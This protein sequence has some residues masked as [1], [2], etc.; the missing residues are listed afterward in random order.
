MIFD[1]EFPKI[2]VHILGVMW[3]SEW[4]GVNRGAGKGT[5]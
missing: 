4:K 3:R 1:T 5:E 2:S